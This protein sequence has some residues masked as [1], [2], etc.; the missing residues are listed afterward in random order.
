MNGLG[1]E[2]PASD[3][4]PASDEAAD[5]GLISRLRHIAAKA[6]PVPAAVISAA[7]AAF[8]LRDVDALVAELIRDSVLDAPVTAMRGGDARMLSFEAGDTVIECEV[9]AHAG[10]RDVKGQLSGG[11]ATLVEAQ[12][13]NTPPVDVDIRPH[14]FFSVRGLPSGPFRLRCRMANGATIVTSWTS[15]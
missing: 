14:G 7:R 6:D 15:V 12:V 9:T 8:A 11:A 13:A 10:G 1:N 5:D 4:Q 2:G 3:G